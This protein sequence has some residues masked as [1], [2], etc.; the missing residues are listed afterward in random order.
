MRGPILLHIKLWVLGQCGN[1]LL[2]VW[3]SLL[4]PVVLTVL[5][6]TVTHWRKNRLWS[7]TDLVLILIYHFFNLS[8]FRQV[9]ESL[10][11]KNTLL[12]DSTTIK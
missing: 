11:C 10:S 8:V 9:L 7:E 3:T 2:Q 6:L 4:D 12:A 1:D 5:F